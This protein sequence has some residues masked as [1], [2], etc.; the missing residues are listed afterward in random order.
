MNKRIYKH[1][2]PLSLS[3]QGTAV[4]VET[5]C[6]T[7]LCVQKQVSN[8]LLYTRLTASFPGQPR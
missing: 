5:V 7:M 3:K 6:I 2:Q 4:M 8:T 1:K